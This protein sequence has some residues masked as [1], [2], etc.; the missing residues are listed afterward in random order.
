MAAAAAAAAAV[1]AAAPAAAAVMLADTER[2]DWYS[3]AGKVNRICRLILF[4]REG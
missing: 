3:S 4:S 1:A 2:A